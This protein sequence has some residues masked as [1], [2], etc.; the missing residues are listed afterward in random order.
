M[1]PRFPALPLFIAALAFISPPSSALE[2][3][4]HEEMIPHVFDLIL[5]L[6]GSRA[7]GVGSQY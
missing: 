4:N 6:S 2:P 7:M 5:E 3:G 1:L